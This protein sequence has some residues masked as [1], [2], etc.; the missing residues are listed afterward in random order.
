MRIGITFNKFS[1]SGDA[2][3]TNY[4]TLI[5]LSNVNQFF[6]ERNFIVKRNKIIVHN[7]A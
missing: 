5:D 4:C 6:L 2:L 1:P 3:I 7:Q